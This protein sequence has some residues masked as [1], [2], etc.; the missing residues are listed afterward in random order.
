MGCFQA[1]LVA[2]KRN[3]PNEPYPFPM[4]EQD[5]CGLPVCSFYM[6]RCHSIDNTTCFGVNMRV[7]WR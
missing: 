4:N 1:V 7:A 5:N 6:K 2:V 3:E